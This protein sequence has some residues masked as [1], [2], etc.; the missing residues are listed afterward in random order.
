MQQ[1]AVLKAF[2]LAG[3][4]VDIG[5]CFG[6]DGGPDETPSFTSMVRVGCTTHPVT[7]HRVGWW[8]RE[9]NLSEYQ[10]YRWL[11]DHGAD[12]GETV[13]VCWSGAGC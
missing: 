1:F 6:L 4:P 8:S 9:I 11:L 3:A 13:L 7:D 5:D 12:D 10:L 2:D